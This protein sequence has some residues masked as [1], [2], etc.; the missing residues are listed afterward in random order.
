MRTSDWSSVT[1]NPHGTD[2][3]PRVNARPSPR[4]PVRLLAALLIPLIAFVVLEQVLGNPTG[5]LAITDGL[6]L[7]WV[8]AYGIWRHRVEPIGLMAAA[9]FAIALVLTIALG[10]TSLP[11]ELRRS[12]FPGAVGIACLVSLALGRPLLSTAAVRLARAHPE[13]TR[14]ARPDLDTPGARRAMAALTAIIGVT[15]VIDAAAQIFLALTLSTSHFGVYARFASYAIIG[16]G[17]AV[18]TVYTRHVRAR[19]R[20][21]PPERMRAP[22]DQDS[23]APTSAGS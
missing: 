11:L 16:S 3:D 8:L 2:S 21:R 5:A 23:Q 1:G 17:L 13:R 18:G 15:G 10:G 4:R 22:G 12:V 9:V 20:R 19:L 6:P 14:G 7:L